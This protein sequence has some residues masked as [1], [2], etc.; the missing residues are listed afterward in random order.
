MTQRHDAGTRKSRHIDD[1]CGIQS[2]RPQQSVRQNQPAFRIRIEDFHRLS[3][4]ITNDIPGLHGAP[5]RQIFARRHQSRHV[6]GKLHVGGVLHGRQH[7]RS[8]RHIKLHL[9][10][11]AGGFKRNTACIKRDALS[12]QHVGLGVAGTP[13]IQ[14]DKDGKVVRTNTDG[15]QSRHLFTDVFPIPNDGLKPLRFIR[16]RLNGIRQQFRR[17]RV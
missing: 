2:V 1:G 7:H 4:V 14:F 3:V 16:Q 13:V 5:R 9:V 10:H 8:A 15:R 12:Y 6:D 17:Q 11:A